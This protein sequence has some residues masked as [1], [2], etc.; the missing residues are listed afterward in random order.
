MTVQ[1]T[2]RRVAGCAM[3]AKLEAV[4]LQENP[5]QQGN[6]D[7]FR[8]LFRSY[9]RQ[10][11]VKCTCRRPSGLRQQDGARALPGRGPAR[12]HRF[13]ESAGGSGDRADTRDAFAHGGISGCAL[14]GFRWRNRAADLQGLAATDDGVRIIRSE[15]ERSL[16]RGDGMVE[17]LELQQDLSE[18]A[19]DLGV[20]SLPAD[21]FAVGIGRFR[22]GTTRLQCLSELVPGR[23]QIGPEAGEMDAIL[24]A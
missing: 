13:V 8:L 4:V 3:P 16:E 5:C 20:R 22:P 12:D 2:G 9:R 7:A 24:L 10:R 14:G 18:V 6:L 19:I 21:H 17:L 11:D 1:T 15:A 23:D